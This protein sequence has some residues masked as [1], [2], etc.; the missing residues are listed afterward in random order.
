MSYSIAQQ[1]NF[2]MFGIPMT[3]PSV[4]GYIGNITDYGQMCARWIQLA[5]FFPFASSV[6]DPSQPDNIY[7]LDDRFMWWAKSALYNR[8]Q[9]LRFMYTCL[10]EASQDGTTCFDPMFYHWPLDDTTFTNVENSFI[11]GDALKVSPV[12][13][14]KVDVVASY[15]PNGDWVNMKNYSDIVSVGDPSVPG[16]QLVELVAPSDHNET[17]NDHLRPGYIVPIQP[18]E[19]WA[20]SSAI[21]INTNG[22]ID[23]VVN[24][25]Y[26]GA[27]VGKLLLNK[28]ELQAELD[29]KEYEYFEFK[30]SNKT[31]NKWDLNEQAKS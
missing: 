10:F 20:H 27:A 19:D 4:C 2:N 11:V 5:T 1:M 21:D 15:F 29:N 23:L 9:Y 31:L 14:A 30:L 17:I 25:D 24:A 3:G 13:T 8:L 6:T 28:G 16:G 18:N 7:E 12:L 26:L 22:K